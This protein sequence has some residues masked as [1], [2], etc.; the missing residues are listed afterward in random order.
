MYILSVTLATLVI[1]PG[2]LKILS[3]Y[4]WEDVCYLKDLLWILLTFVLRRKRRPLFLAVDRFIE[5][6]ALHPNRTFI[7]FENKSYSYEDANKESNKIANALRT[8]ARLQAGETVALLMGNEPTFMFTWLALA[9]LGCPVAFLNHN[10]RS[11][12]LLH[13]FSCCDAKVIIAAVGKEVTNSSREAF[14]D[15]VGSQHYNSK[16]TI[17]VFWGLYLQILVFSKALAV[18]I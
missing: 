8:H 11:K 4:F 7:I 9:K 5:Q 17:K 14:R 13:C 10:I 16:I 6:S 15:H 12:S 3:P 1:I 18:F 2:L